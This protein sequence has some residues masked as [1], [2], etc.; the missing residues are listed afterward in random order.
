MLHANGAAHGAAEASAMI[1]NSD[2][3]L[4]NQV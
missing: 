2:D 3:D 4:G 1:G